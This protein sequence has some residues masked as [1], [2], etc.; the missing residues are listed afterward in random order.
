MSGNEFMAILLESSSYIE[1]LLK[2]SLIAEN[3][4]FQEQYR[5]YTGGRFSEVKYV[6]DFLITTDKTRLIV[7]C[8]GFHYHAG[9]DNR[10][11]QIERDQW[12]IQKGFQIVHFSTKDIESNIQYV[13]RTI[14]SILNNPLKYKCSSTNI[15]LSNKRT[16]KKHSTT[17]D[18]FDVL[19]FC[20]YKQTPVGVYIAYKYKSI[21]Y[22]RWS[23]ERLKA[24]LNVPQDMIETTAIYLS[25]LDLKRSSNVKIYFSGIIYNDKYDVTEKFKTLIKSLNNGEKL[26]SE[27]KISLSYVGFH[28]NYRINKKEPQKTMNE[29]KSRCLQIANNS[30]NSDFVPFFE[31]S[32]ITS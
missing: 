14:K 19:L 18:N 5:I 20:Y 10:K 9:Y 30:P 27:Q 31:Y 1:L 17:K 15:R 8:D 12:L 28:G 4:P 11:K 13:I 26:L 25:L 32:E 29:L 2:K 21:L 22:D 23:E 7:E 6:A 3:I 16:T 24:C